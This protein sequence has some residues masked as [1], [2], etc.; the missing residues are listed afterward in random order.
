MTTTIRRRKPKSARA[1]WDMFGELLALRNIGGEPATD[2]ERAYVTIV[3]L[4]DDG[5]A[6]AER[7]ALC[8]KMYG[9]SFLEVRGEAGDFAPRWDAGRA[10]FAAR[11]AEWDARAAMV[12][13]RGAGRG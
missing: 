6:D 1:R 13:A 4:C 10:E 8:L 7:D 11:L 12:D 9:K 5:M 3:G 2:E